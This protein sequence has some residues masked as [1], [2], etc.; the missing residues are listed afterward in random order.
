[1]CIICIDIERDRLRFK[2]SI[3][4]LRE[5]YQTIDYDHR[6]EVTRKVLK[7]EIEERKKKKEAKNEA[8]S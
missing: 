1:M 7:L 6:D 5:R 8:S 2:E 3:K 4:N